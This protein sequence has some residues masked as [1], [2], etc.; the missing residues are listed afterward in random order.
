[1]M[2]VNLMP[3]RQR[4]RRQHQRRGGILG[5]VIL[6]AMVGEILT[7]YW[8]HVLNQQQEAM[9]PIG[10]AAQQDI[11]ALYRRTLS[12]KQQFDQQRHVWQQQQLQQRD[13]VQ[14]LDFIH[15]LSTDMPSSIWLSRVQ[16]SQQSV[17]MQGFSDSVSVLHQFCNHLRQQGRAR[18]VALGALQREPSG[19]LRF[20]L[21]L[22][23]G[24]PEKDH[25]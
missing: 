23:L 21:Q 2:K 6:I 17:E 9:L 18:K 14:W 5:G 24:Q 25:E 8:Q 10:S 7:G 11:T 13:L 12:L 4:R 20:S 19:T 1:M 16:K 3:W 15:V 22:Q